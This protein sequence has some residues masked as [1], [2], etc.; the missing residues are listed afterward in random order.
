LRRLLSLTASAFFILPCFIGNLQA[1]T[2]EDILKKAAFEADFIAI[3]GEQTA[4]RGLKKEEI[5]SSGERSELTGRLSTGRDELADT[6]DLSVV[7]A[8][9]QRLQV[10]YTRYYESGLSWSATGYQRQASALNSATAANEQFNKTL[11]SVNYPLHGPAA[12][13]VPLNQ[14]GRELVLQIEE[15]GN[16]TELTNRQIKT[17][18]TWLEVCRLRAKI[19][20]Q[21]EDYKW[22]SKAMSIK[23]RARSKAGAFDQR[24]YKI[25]DII[26]R[27][28][29]EQTGRELGNSFS[30]LQAYTGPLS[31]EEVDCQFQLPELPAPEELQAGYAKQALFLNAIDI[32][33]QLAQNQLEQQEILKAP[34]VQLQGYAGRTDSSGSTGSNLGV[35]LD[36]TYRFGGGKPQKEQITREEL[37]ILEGVKARVESEA[38]L[39]VSQDLSILGGLFQAQTLKNDQLQLMLAQGREMR[40]L[41]RLSTQANLPLYG[42]YRKIADLKMSVALSSLAILEQEIYIW[43]AAGKDFAAFNPLIE[44]P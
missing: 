33:Q 14:A 21:N 22:A 23:R 29:Q 20:G 30:K 41:A 44:A 39:Q 25:E 19:D 15:R 2:L 42:I 8:Q 24:G 36:V 10:K 26:L 28:Q 32:K 34:D 18:G 9:T 35:A 27:Q 3:Q 38:S 43:S 40:A 4:L 31:P 17:A 7:A 11:F 37:L 13:K 16:F 6:Q 12:T 5:R 1:L